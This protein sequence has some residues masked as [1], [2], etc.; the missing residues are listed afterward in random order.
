MQSRKRPELLFKTTAQH[1]ATAG[2]PIGDVLFDE[3]PAYDAEDPLREQSLI[4]AGAEFVEQVSHGLALPHEAHGVQ[5]QTPLAGKLPTELT[6]RSGN[7]LVLGR[8]IPAVFVAQ[9]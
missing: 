6:N 5:E 2:G 9:P 1:G 7:I 3:Q 8:A 4:A